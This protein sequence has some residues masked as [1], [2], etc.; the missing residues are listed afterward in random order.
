VE[1]SYT[2]ALGNAGPSA[3]SVGDMVTI[4]E[5]PVAAPINTAPEPTRS[6]PPSTQGSSPAT[7][8]AAGKSDDDAGS[9]SGSGS[10][11]SR[12]AQ[13]FSN[14]DIV[15]AQ[16]L[17]KTYALTQLL[18]EQTELQIE[19][20]QITVDNPTDDLPVGNQS[21]IE[22][23]FGWQVL[24]SWAVGITSITL[25]GIGVYKAARQLRTRRLVKKFA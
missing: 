1:N 14:Y 13:I 5:Q 18:P 25:A 19:G 7:P 16:P 11:A 23:W 20:P 15:P 21:S 9:G 3:V 6:E 22:T 10:G 2:D 17:K 8:I 4:V 24:A 12:G